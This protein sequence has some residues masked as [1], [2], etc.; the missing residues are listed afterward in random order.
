MS[1]VAEQNNEL[2]MRNHQSRP[3]GSEPFPEVNAIS[4][5][6]RGRDENEDVVMVVEEI[7]DT[8][9]KFAQFKDIRR[10][11]YHIETMNEDNV[12]YLYIT[13]IISGQKLIMEKLPA[14]SS[15]LYHTTIK[16]IES[17]VVV[18]QKFNNPKVFVLWHDRLGH[19]GS[20]MMRRII[21]HSHGHPLKNQKILSPNEYSCVAC[22]QDAFI[23]TKKVTKSHIPAA[24]TPAR[25]DVHVGQL[26]NESKIRLKRGRPIGSKN[27]TPRKK[28]TQEKLGHSRRDHQMMDQFKIDKSIALEEAQI[29]QKA[30]EEAHIK[31]EA[32]EEAQIPE[33]LV[34]DIIRNDEDPE[35]RHVEECRHRNDWP[36]WKEAIQAELNSLTKREVFGPV[37]QTPKD[38][39]PVGYKWV[40]V[41]KRNENNEIIR[42]KA[43][44]VAQVYVDDL[45]LV[46][47]PEELTRTTNYLKKEF[48]MKALGKT[49]FCLG[50]QIE[51]FPNGVL[52]H[53]STYIKK[54]LKRFY[55][56]KA[57]PLSFPMVVRSL[58]VKKDPFRPCEKDEELLGPKVPYLSAIG[59]L[60]YLVNCTRPDIV[61][62]INLLARYSSAP[63]RRHWNDVGYLSDPHKG[64]SQTGYVF[65]CNGTAISWRSV[66]QTMVATSSNHSE[67]LAIH[68]ASRECIWLRSMIQHIRESCGLSSIKGDLTILFEDNVACITQITGGYIKRD[69]TKHISPKFFYTHELQKS[70]EIDVQQIRSSDNLAD[71]FTKSLPT[72][73]FKKLIHRIGMRQL[74]DI[75]MRGVCL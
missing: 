75:D 24:N 19:P 13:S 38:V 2:L 32:P 5:Q 4:S 50:L 34:S 66:K 1:S 64:K 23:D 70:G 9:K 68:E 62:S 16:P 65:N 7:P 26:T 58:D 61:F 67:M 72:S 36:K 21:E 71:L 29:M 55:M 49:K 25:I 39:K 35:P 8:M 17:Y 45:N 31:Q 56:D 69:R 33:N 11:G 57:H 43:R 63:T 20:S 51:H 60:M 3:T 41:R 46:G 54:V 15:G 73:T 22:S 47:T 18:N 52:V 6:T 74:K 53:Q 28:R 59:A 14:F 40:F 10:N 44:L 30:L 48:E 12:E 37:V 27:V 42:Y